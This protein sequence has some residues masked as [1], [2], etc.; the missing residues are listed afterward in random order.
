MAN[1][2]DFE[3]IKKIVSF[4]SQ[5]S[6]QIKHRECSWLEFKESFNWLSKSD[7]AKTIASFANNK[8]GYIIFGI[9]N[10]PRQIIGLQNNNFDD[11]DEAK[12]TEYLNSVFSPEINYEKDTLTE[13]FNKIGLFY[14]YQSSNKPV[15]CIKTDKEIKEGEI[16][17]RYNA[18]S[19]KIKYPE[20]KKLIEQIKEETTKQWRNALTKMSKI[21]D[22]ENIDFRITDNENAP[23]MRIAEEDIL[24]NY[25]WTYSDLTKQLKARYSDFKQGSKFHELKKKYIKDL[26]LCHTRKLNPNNPKTSHQTFYSKKIIKEFNNYYSIKKI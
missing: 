1:N 2:I 19:E 15:V 9:K 25:P 3:E 4:E 18:R 26:S 12:I 21:S 13:N 11:M 24:T 20:I 10:K 22:P 14:V 16:Y 8:G 5:D 6:N 23:L 17:Y 7:Y